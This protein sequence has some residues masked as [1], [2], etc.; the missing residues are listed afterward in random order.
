MADVHPEA[1]M[2]PT[3]ICPANRISP[4]SISPA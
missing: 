3:A 1:A 2:L 4:A